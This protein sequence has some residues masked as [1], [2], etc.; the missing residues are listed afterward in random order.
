MLGVVL[1]VFYILL[2]AVIVPQAV[3]VDDH[4]FTTCLLAFTSISQKS[5][6]Y[7]KYCNLCLSHMQDIEFV[8]ASGQSAGELGEGILFFFWVV[9]SVF[10]V[11][12]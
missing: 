5:C 8:T 9:F 3:S 4:M 1:N 2:I 6:H 11:H 12:F 10:L 7:P